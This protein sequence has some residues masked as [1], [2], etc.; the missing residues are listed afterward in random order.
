MKRASTLNHMFE[1]EN[2][3]YR[4]KEFSIQKTITDENGNKKQRRY[5]AA[6]TIVK[7]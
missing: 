2:T 6:W 3:P 5:K 4:I 1:E 7:F